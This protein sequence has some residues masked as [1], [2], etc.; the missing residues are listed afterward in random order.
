MSFQTPITIAEALG[1]IRDREYVLPAIQREFVWSRDKITRLFDSLMRGYPIGSFLMWQVEAANASKFVFYDVM[2]DY[3]E[4]DHAHC[5]PT[6]PLG[7]RRVTAVLDG[8]QRLTA[9]NI[10]LR[11]A[12]TQKLPR[13][14]ANNPAAYPS[15]ELFVDLL[16]Q[17]ADD[18]LGVEYD[19]RFIPAA[20][21]DHV[22]PGAA[23]F[24]VRDI[25]GLTN[26]AGLLAELQRRGLGNDAT[27][28]A[29]LARLSEI[30]HVQPSISFF[31]EQAQELDKVL[32]IF[33]RV[34]SGGMVLSYSDLLL[35]V[36]TAQW[37]DRDARDTIHGLVDDLNAIGN[38]FAFSKDLVLKTGLVLLDKGDIRFHVDNFDRTTMA[39]LDKRW[40]EIDRVLRSAAKLLADFGFSTPT[41]TANSVLIPIAYYL[42]R[43]GVPDNYLTA[44]AHAADRD[45]IKRWV[46]RAL[47]KAGVWGSGLDRLLTG[48]RGVI[49]KDGTGGWPTESLERE[50]SRQ[51]KPLQFQMTE[52]DDLLDGKYGSKRMFPLL[53]LLYPGVDPREQFHEDHIFPRSILRSKTKL[54]AAKVP[55]AQL[56]QFIDLCDRVPNLQLLRGAD[57]IGKSDKLPLEW[58][59]GHFPTA[60]QRESW[61]R[62]YDA[63]D[64]PADVIEFPNFF[65]ARRGRMRT[66]L[67]Q[68]LGAQENAAVPEPVDGAPTVDEPDPGNEGL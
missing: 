50:M 13:L 38:G 62:E 54:R 51:G 10:G 57:N 18:D 11:G 19:F 59:D 48:L 6:G 20:D 12:H 9:L 32:N 24:R 1:K 35:S 41:L 14:W 66:R 60:E 5:A 37:T 67:A 63:M 31:L 29:V 3:H 43:R 52:I 46:Q 15:T 49:D 44:P 16:H 2:R 42:H 27:A 34:N 53:A 21:L 61:L 64:I 23:W 26:M 25:M 58:L 22:K 17:G 28:G 65:A 68:L 47:I 55:E 39:E 8:Q 4:R 36:A 56:E 30:V 7:E 40:D 45:A 33:I